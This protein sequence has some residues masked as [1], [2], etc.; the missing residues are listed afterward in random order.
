MK[1]FSSV[2]TRRHF[3]ASGLTLAAGVLCLPRSQAKSPRPAPSNRI[4]LGVIG[5]G[6]QAMNDIRSFFQDPRVQIVAVCDVNRES[7]E[8]WAGRPGGREV[9]KRLVE[10]HEA[11]FYRSGKYRGCEV[12][13]DY[14]EMLARPEI[15]AVLIDTPDHWHALQVIDAAR[16]GKDIYCQKPVSLTVDEGRLMRD[17]VRH[18]RRVFQTGSQQRSIQSF[19]RSAELIR[20]GHLGRLLEVRVGLP[21]G[22]PDHAHSADRKAPG[23][24]PEGFD[25]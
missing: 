9:G 17:V 18:H 15:D 6:N 19:I 24:V 25:Y 21:G 4:T 8:Y 14:R 16:A 5:C 22:R 13:S 11:Q 20:N 12:F 3:V 1:P 23:P 2:T 7:N 10:E